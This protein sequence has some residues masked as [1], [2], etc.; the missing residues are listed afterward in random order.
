[1]ALPC[2]LDANQHQESVAALPLFP[3]SPSFQE[4]AGPAGYSEGL[5]FTTRG[6]PEGV[7][8]SHRR[9]RND[10]PRCFRDTS[11]SAHERVPMVQSSVCAPPGNN[12]YRRD[13][14]RGR[15][16]LDGDVP[17]VDETTALGVIEMAAP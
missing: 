3:G 7:S 4:G 13:V 15:L 6:V 11:N 17:I 1:M 2:G 9:G 14:R 12:L 10:V 16:G 5:R 8:R